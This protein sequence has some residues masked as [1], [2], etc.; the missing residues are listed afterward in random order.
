MDIYDRVPK[1]E[2]HVHLE[3][4]IPAGTMWSLINKYGGDP[5]VGSLDDLRRRFVYRD[6]AGF[7]DTWTW[8]NGFLREY[9]DFTLIA[10]DVARAFASQNIR[11][12]EMFVSPS[13]FRKSGLR[14]QE[15][16]HAIHRGLR[17]ANDVRIQL[18]VDLVRDYGPEREITT[19]YEINEVKHLGILGIG[20]G[21]SEHEYPPEPFSGLYERARKLGFRTDVH[22]GEAAGPGSVWGAIRSLHP[23]RIGHATSA[24]RDPALLRHCAE[25]AIALELCPLSNVRTGAVGSHR[26]YPLL[27]F[28]E[29]GTHFSI[30]TDDPAMFGN[31]LAD[32]YR[33]IE[34]SFGISRRGICDII[35]NSVRTAWMDEAE[36]K[37][38]V[39][40]FSA[41]IDA[42][43]NVDASGG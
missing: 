11:Y 3:G 9:E 16:I 1:I 21:G 8:K 39:E 4:A 13:L 42:L 10:A 34:Q 17:Q 25:H 43:M 22:A 6:F 41:E 30:N 38:L 28:M 37:E 20:I 36:Q 15:I 19:L 32:E 14:P 12:A 40:V 31:L 33:M 29:Y 2:L 5:S 7:I 24:A 18:V 27:V 26:E 35:L 23:D